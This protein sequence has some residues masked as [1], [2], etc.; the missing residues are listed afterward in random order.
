M[1][2][3]NIPA[4]MFAYIHTTYIAYK[5]IYIHTYTYDVHKLMWQF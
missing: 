5:N 3:T 2:A 4:Y 1:I